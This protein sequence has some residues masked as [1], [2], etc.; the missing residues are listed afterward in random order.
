[1]G[2]HGGPCFQRCS[3]FSPR[4]RRISSYA[5]SC[6]M[7][8]EYVR[9]YSHVGHIPVACQNGTSFNMPCG[10]IEVSPFARFN[11]DSMSYDI[12]L[13]DPITGKTIMLD[14]PHQL[15]GGTYCMGGT[16]ELW[17]NITWNYSKH[18]QRVL[19]AEKGIRIIYGKPAVDTIPILQAAISQL[20]DDV[21]NDYWKATE[22]NAKAALVKL[23][24]MAKMRPDGVW[25]GD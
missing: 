17:L 22:G 2:L 25:D 3:S 20:K 13:N 21:D 18:F 16:R 19:D 9:E 24:T 6:D 5:S 7:Q 14:E 23:L 8:L 4:N 12:S 1:M 10:C 11:K 15:R